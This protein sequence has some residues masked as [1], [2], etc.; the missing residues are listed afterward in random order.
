LV[1]LALSGSAWAEECPRASSP[2]EARQLAGRAFSEGQT[3]FDAGNFRAALERFQCSYG[4]VPH[5]N[6]LYNM[7][8]C[9]ESLDDLEGAIRYFRLYVETFPDIEGRAE[10]ETRLRQLEARQAESHAPPTSEPNP[11][12]NPPRTVTPAMHMTLAR[13]LAWV[14]LG[15]GAGLAIL[16]GGI[17]GGSISRNGDF[18]AANDDYLSDNFLSDEERSDLDSQRSAGQSMEAAGWA[19][20]GVGLASLAASIVLFFAFDSTEPAA[21]R[22]SRASRLSLGPLVLSQGGGVSVAGDF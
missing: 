3:L 13:R 10:V 15:V 17:Y 11:Q 20:L 8:E 19:L 16:G 14:T 7:G 9:A 1:W 21:G 18:Q 12:P 22:G 6:T 4:L 5:H 2:D